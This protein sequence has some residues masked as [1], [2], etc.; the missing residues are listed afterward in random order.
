MNYSGS[1]RIITGG[2]AAMP[3][4]PS[5]P[6]LGVD[7]SGLKSPQIALFWAPSFVVRVEEN[8]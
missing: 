6:S 5:A 2:N 4:V 7:Y 1:M 8:A 3:S